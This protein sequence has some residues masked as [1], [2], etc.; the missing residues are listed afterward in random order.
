MVKERRVLRN[1]LDIYEAELLADANALVVA[2]DQKRY[3]VTKSLD[4]L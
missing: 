2:N 3:L 4:V 1:Q